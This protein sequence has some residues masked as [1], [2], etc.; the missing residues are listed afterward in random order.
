MIYFI[1]LTWH[2]WTTSW[3]TE[4]NQDIYLSV[5]KNTDVN[6]LDTELGLVLQKREPTQ[7]KQDGPY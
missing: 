5:I 3:D 7:L 4:V 2:I 1:V 6:N